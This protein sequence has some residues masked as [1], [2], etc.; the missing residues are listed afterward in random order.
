MAPKKPQHSDEFIKEVAA[1]L[2]I[3]EYKGLTTSAQNLNKTE[4]ALCKK[5]MEV[6]DQVLS[7]GADESEAK[8]ESDAARDREVYKL[9]MLK[10]HQ[11][12]IKKRR[13]QRFRRLSMGLLRRLRWECLG[14]SVR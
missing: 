12:R 14:L 5:K 8:T 1:E 3:A 13:N 7:T 9:K 2:G 4:E 6:Y 11:D 10:A